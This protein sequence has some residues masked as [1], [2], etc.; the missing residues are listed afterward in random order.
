MSR[1]AIHEVAA[2][3]CDALIGPGAIERDDLRGAPL[4]T[5]SWRVFGRGGHPAFEDWSLDAWASNP[6]LKVRTSILRGDRGPVLAR[7]DLL[8]TVP[9]SR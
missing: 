6:H 9:T 3:R 8:I 2:G 1:D 4:G 7:T 5:W